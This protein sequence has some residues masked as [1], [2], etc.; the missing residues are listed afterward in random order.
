MWQVR[1]SFQRVIIRGEWPD[2]EAASKFL[3]SQ[4]SL[5]GFFIARDEREGFNCVGEGR[6]SCHR[7]G[8]GAAR[9]KGNFNSRGLLEAERLILGRRE[10]HMNGYTVP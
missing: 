3:P 9:Q 6:I 7:G 4:I 8:R 10:H 5:L 1:G 2:S